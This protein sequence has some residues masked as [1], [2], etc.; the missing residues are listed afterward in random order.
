MLRNKEIRRGDQVDLTFILDGDVSSDAIVFIAKRDKTLTSAR[1]IEKKNTVAGGGNTEL[2]VAYSST[3]LKSTVTVHIL[4]GNTQALTD[5]F[6]YFDIYNNTDNETLIHG[7][8]WI[9]ADVQSP[10]DSGSV[11]SSEIPIL[12]KV[13]YLEIVDGEITKESYYGFNTNPT[14]TVGET[15]S[16]DTLTITSDGELELEGIP[17]SNRKDWNTITQTD[18]DSI[19]IAWDSGTFSGKTITFIWRYYSSADVGQSTPIEYGTQSYGTTAER[20]VFSSGTNIGFEY[21]DTDIQAPVWWSGSSW[22][23]S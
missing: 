2:E 23:D 1:I 13:I 7:K 14:A 16:S 19:V 9:L 15:E 22:S 20:P 4:E 21:Y 17:D 18:E 3:N 12:N 8:M 6:L 5:E 10:Y 11:P